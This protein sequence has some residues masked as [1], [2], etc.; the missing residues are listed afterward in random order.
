MT[1]PGT[2]THHHKLKAIIFTI[3]GVNYECQVQQWTLNPGVSEG[4]RMYSFCPPD[5][6]SFIMEPDPEPTLD[7][8]F[9]AYW[10]NG[11]I[12]DFLWQHTGEV[13][14]YVLEH[15]PGRPD[16]HV[17]FSG[18]LRVAAPPT[19]GEARSVEQHEVS[20]QLLDLPTYERVASP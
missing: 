15:N 1:S 13:A 4:E 5:G 7:V 12:S 6:G 20:F 3:G 17:R 10:A 19:G 14:D 2:G 8:T 9:Y 16:E 18:Q 11:A